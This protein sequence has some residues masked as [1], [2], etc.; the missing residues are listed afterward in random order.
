MNS[1]NMID[2]NNINN[3][4]NRYSYGIMIVFYHYRYVMYL[5]KISLHQKILTYYIGI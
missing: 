2:N 4:N 1:S 3:S 5:P